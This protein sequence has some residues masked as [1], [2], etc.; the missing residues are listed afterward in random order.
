[1]TQTQTHQ[2]HLQL[3]TY[4]CFLVQSRAVV[5]SPIYMALP[6]IEWANTNTFCSCWKTP[7][8]D[9]LNHIF[10]WITL[11]FA[12]PQSHHYGRRQ[13]KTDSKQT[14]FPVC[15]FLGDQPL[16]ME[17]CAAL[18]FGNQYGVIN[19]YPADAARLF[20]RNWWLKI[21][22]FLSEKSPKNDNRKFKKERHKLINMRR[23]NQNHLLFCP[24]G[25]C[26]DSM[27]F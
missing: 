3:I 18:Q 9:Q 14:W 7:L 5:V 1:M 13:T 24:D 17:W 16:V 21:S 8:S 12:V 20:I 15:I 26:G 2:A 19:K 4:W 23:F 25:K 10:T 11:D 22:L 6:W 27:S